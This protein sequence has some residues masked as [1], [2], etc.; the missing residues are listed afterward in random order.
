MARSYTPP[1]QRLSRKLNVLWIWRVLF[2]LHPTVAVLVMMLVSPVAMWLNDLLFV[3]GRFIP[4]RDQWLS[5]LFDFAL[6]V[7]AGVLIGLIRKIDMEFFPSWVARRSL[8]WLLVLGA[9][10]LGAGHVWQERASIPSLERRL[11][12]N[13]L[14][15]NLFLYPFLG[16]TLALLVLGAIGIMIHGQYWRA[17]HFVAGIALV[18]ALIGGWAWA[19]TYDRMHPYTPTGV[20]KSDIANPPDPWCGGWLTKS[21]CGPPQR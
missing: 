6:A 17:P 2:D 12:P 18:C 21:L 7:A 19:G 4:L 14:Y 11:G 8:H 5:A 16:Y 20:H 3:H 15:H 10:A 1:P 9:F 13:S